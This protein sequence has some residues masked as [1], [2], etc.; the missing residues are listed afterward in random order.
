MN[1]GIWLYGGVPCESC[2]VPIPVEI[3]K[4]ICAN[5]DF[6]LSYRL[7]VVQD[8]YL[9][10]MDENYV[11]FDIGEVLSDSYTGFRG[12]GG[13]TFYITLPNGKKIQT[14]NLWHKGTLPEHLRKDWPI[15]PSVLG[16]H[17][18]ERVV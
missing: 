8:P 15:K 9:H 5:C 12:F 10:I 13:S 3:E 6:W 7:E 11:Q 1:R 14:S 16:K 4:T 2:R 17:I 18:E